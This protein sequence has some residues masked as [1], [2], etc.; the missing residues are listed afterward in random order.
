V[1]SPD[2]LA[3]DVVDATAAVR[4][5]PGAVAAVEQ[6]GGDDLDRGA[7]GDGLDGEQAHQDEQLD[8]AGLQRRRPAEQQ[9]DERP[10]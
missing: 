7:H 10:G 8:G 9:P 6:A 3:R 2:D 5:G 1:G 4:S